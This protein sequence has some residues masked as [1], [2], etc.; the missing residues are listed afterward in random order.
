[1]LAISCPSCRIIPSFLKK[2]VKMQDGIRVWMLEI[3]QEEK[4]RFPAELSVDYGL[5]TQIFS[6]GL[7]TDLVT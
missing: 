3:F 5:Y 6:L 7:N 2:L 4:K 1:M